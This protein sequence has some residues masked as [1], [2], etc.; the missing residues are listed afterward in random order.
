MDTTMT[1]TESEIARIR[2]V[3]IAISEKNWEHLKALSNAPIPN[4]DV[5]LK[6]IESFGERILP[7]KEGFEASILHVDLPNGDEVF[8]I[9]MRTE[10]HDRSDIMLVMSRVRSGGLA[11]LNVDY[12]YRS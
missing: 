11:S 2:E 7:L 4:F 6:Y 1:L 9:P 8:E 10:M 3:S 5:F 12:I